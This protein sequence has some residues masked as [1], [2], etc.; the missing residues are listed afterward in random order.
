[1]NKYFVMLATGQISKDEFYNKL[2]E[3]SIANGV[4]VEEGTLNYEMGSTQLSTPAFIGNNGIVVCS[5]F[6]LI[7]QYME[8]VQSKNIYF[9]N[10]SAKQEF[11]I[12]LVPHED[13]LLQVAFHTNITYPDFLEN[14]ISAVKQETERKLNLFNKIGKLREENHLKSEND[15]P[16]LA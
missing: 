8:H 16:K 13:S 4:L 6:E 7:D 1:M 10:D 14:K 5:D 3:N 12:L 15:G 9:V 2:K 11:P